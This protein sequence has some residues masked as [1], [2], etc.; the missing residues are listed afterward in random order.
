MREI[1]SLL[2]DTNEVRRKPGPPSWTETQARMQEV[3][4]NAPAIDIRDRASFP[5]FNTE[6]RL[7]LKSVGLDP[8]AGSHTQGIPCW[9]PRYE[10]LHP[11]TQQF[12]N[13]GQPPEVETRRVWSTMFG[14][15]D[16]CG[17]PIANWIDRYLLKTGHYCDGCHKDSIRNSYLQ[18]ELKRKL[19]NSIISEY[20]GY[21]ADD[22]DFQDL[23]LWEPGV[24]TFLGAAMRTGK[25]REVSNEMRSLAQQ[26]LGHGIM[27][28][29]RVSL[30]R[31]LA[32]EL[33]R[34]DSYGAWGLW[35]EGVDSTYRT[36]NRYI[37]TYGAIACMPSLPLVE[38]W[39]VE[40][41]LRRL[42]MAIDE[43][44]FCYNL[45]SLCTQ[46]ALKVKQ[47]LRDIIKTTGLV[48]SGQTE[49]TLSLEAFA[50]EM[51]C[52]EIVGFYNTAAP[53]DAP[54]RMI[55]HPDTVLKTN[56][57]IGGVMDDIHEALQVPAQNIYV[58]CSSRR[59]A[60]ILAEIFV[61]EN[62]VVYTAYTKGDPRADA[63]LKNQRV[64]DTRLF[65]GTSAAG[66]GIS[67]WDPK[68]K[69][70]IAS[71][72]NFGSRDA[73]MNSQMT[74][75]DRR[76]AEVLLHYTDF[77]FKLPIRPTEIESVSLYHEEIK[78]EEQLLEESRGQ[79]SKAGIQKIARASALTTFADTEFETVIEHHLSGIG[80]RPIVFEDARALP[81]ERIKEISNQRSELRK[82]ELE[83]K[84]QQGSI[85]L[86]N[87]DILMTRE[88]RTQGMQNKLS[89]KERIA[90][91]A[92]NFYACAVG[93]NDQVDRFQ[94]N[95]EGHY[96]PIE[97]P[98]D[99]ILDD[100]DISVAIALTK[101][102]IDVRTL[103]KQR[104]G[105]LA[106][107]F[108]EFIQGTLQ[109]TL[110]EE[111][112]ITAIDDDRFLGQ[113]IQALLAALVGNV[114]TTQSLATTVREVLNFNGVRTA[115][116]FW[117]E[118][119][120]GALGAQE[121]HRARFLDFAD[122]QRLVDWIRDFISDYYPA[123]IE[124][125]DDHYALRHAKDTDTRLASFRRWLLHQSN[126]PQLPDELPIF[127]P[128][129]IPA[130]NAEAKQH[131]RDMRENG[132]ILQDIA[133]ETGLS[134]DSVSK[135]TKDITVGKE[136][137]RQQRAKR[138][139]EKE[140]LKAEAYRL[141]IE[142]GMSYRQ[143]AQEL[144]DRGL[145]DKVKGPRAIGY[146]INEFTNK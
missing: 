63:V 16:T 52:D 20:Q 3:I 124:K 136:T 118:I 75:R 111:L 45:L 99:G 120:R 32:H 135:A 10:N 13:N 146:W 92:A 2:E 88:I 47:I 140:Q 112:E 36:P 107:H 145:T 87:Y 6:E 134:L 121:Y 137:V 119:K 8:N 1:G 58:F 49:S 39:A 50:E 43:I 80:N 142:E 76:G 114:F 74:I 14:Q 35:H 94:Q 60:E 64:T 70:I 22:P 95:D 93:W 67:I 100:A 57:V 27:L 141:H 106:T 21:L 26:G 102:N 40:N 4:K 128:T 101:C 53:N 9:T 84:I 79:F 29:P 129:Q 46:Q 143:I 48:I 55:K 104:R 113:F 7:L 86:E 51:E 132:A 37:G 123:H 144:A 33:H 105:Y 133:K 96:I 34:R 77:N 59:D 56:H 117:G 81:D 110:E 138:R 62:P 108:P 131:A 85:I 103:K 125:D 130:A 69:T 78:R 115:D 23:R 24:I 68:P 73:N 126:P 66:V 82:R 83:D 54:V 44:D 139:A 28:M 71:G 15:C 41:G 98:F 12:A 72:I 17:G 61:S 90:H 38:K 89:A 25:T 42:Y 19:P 109:M 5:Y 65:I 91:E 97:K 127:Q 116:K 30:V 11:L 31:Y 122:D 18:L